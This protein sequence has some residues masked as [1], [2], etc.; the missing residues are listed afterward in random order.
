MLS[1]VSRSRKTRNT[2]SSDLRLRIFEQWLDSVPKV[3]SH[4]CRQDSQIQYL[5]QAFHSK[6]EVFLEYR[7]SC[8]AKSVD[9]FGKTKFYSLLKNYNISVFQPKKDHCDVQTPNL[10]RKIKKMSLNYSFSFS[11][12]V[13]FQNN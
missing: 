3:E 11:F 2:D 5:N 1:A 13:R 12:F 6:S 9:Y 10:V 4:Y 7:R 8:T